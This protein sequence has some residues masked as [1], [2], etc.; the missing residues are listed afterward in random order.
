MNHSRFSIPITQAAIART[1]KMPLRELILEVCCSHYNEKGLDNMIP[2]GSVFFH[3]GPKDYLKKAV[4]KFNAI[5]A[6]PALMTTDMEEGPGHMIHGGT[7]FPSLA[8]CSA[9]KEPE[10]AYQMGK[11]SAIEGRDVGY[12]WTLAPCV[13]INANPDTPTCTTRTAGV[14]AE[15]VLTY[16]SKYIHGCQD[17]GLMATAKHFP[18]DGFGI[19]DQHLTTPEIPQSFEQWQ[20]SSGK[21]Y[22]QLIDEGV[23]SIMPGHISFPAYDDVD[24]R[25]GLYPPATLSKK[26]MTQLLK[27]E[28]GFDGLIVSDAIDMSG[29][30]GFINL[31]DACAQFFEAGGDVLLFANPDDY[32]LQ[33]MYQRIEQ[34]LLTRQTLENRAQR[35][36]S[37]KEKLGFFDAAANNV[38]N[39]PVA[40]LDYKQHQQIAD[41]VINDAIR[42]VRDRQGVLPINDAKNKSILHITVF[43]DTMIASE[44]DTIL[45]LNDLLQQEFKSAEHIDDPGPWGIVAKVKSGQYDHIICSL[46][47]GYKFG[48]NVVRMHGNVARNLMKGWMHMGVDVTFVSH[49]H[50]HTHLEYLAV[51][52]CV[53]NMHGTTEGGLQPLL[54]RLVGR[55]PIL[56]I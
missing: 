7:K 26:I 8:G 29:F 15:Q 5:S 1:Q 50:Q 16:T 3:P 30:C 28:M 2:T 11:I 41:R 25:N 20:Q 14:N 53:I 56:A 10:N 35:I 43:A 39:S 48:T 36:L 4:K 21:V 32:F 44:K 23:M 55:T 54:D 33:Q 47:N 49:Y 52:D 51:M 22:Q 34:G 12:N 42:L 19:Y 37:L 40:E 18:G 46:G 27:Q 45:K 9:T 6:T 38:F 17:H 31:Y 13:D 24:P